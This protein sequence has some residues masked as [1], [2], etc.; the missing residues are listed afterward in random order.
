MFTKSFLSRMTERAIKTFCQALLSIL[1]ISQTSLLTI[2]WT[3]ALSVAT[4]AFIISILTSVITL[5]QSTPSGVPGGYVEPK[6]DATGDEPAATDG[7]KQTNSRR[8]LI[9]K[10]RRNK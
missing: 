2:D 4:L 10:T 1:T 6:A 5:P 3:G 7:S 8:D 9:K